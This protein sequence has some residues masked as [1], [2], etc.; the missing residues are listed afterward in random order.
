MVKAT[1]FLRA[2]SFRHGRRFAA[3]TLSSSGPIGCSPVI[4]QFR[5]GQTRE[6]PVTVTEIALCINA[7]AALL[8]AF[9]QMIC[10]LRRPP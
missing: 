6:D 5:A 8:A 3:L 9:A 1:C 2:A 10:A 4:A 7:L